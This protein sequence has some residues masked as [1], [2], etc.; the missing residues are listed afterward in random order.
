MFLLL[1]IIPTQVIAESD[2][3]VIDLTTDPVK[4]LFDLSNV[5]PGDSVYRNLV[6]KNDGDQD[7]NYL[8]SSKFTSG[9]EDFYNKLDLVIKDSNGVLYDGKLFKFNKLEPRL[10]KSN[11]TDQLLFYIKVPD[12]LGNT[13]QGLRTEFQFKF[14]VEGTLGGLLPAN[15]PRLPDTGG[16][17]FNILVSGFVMIL[18]GLFI[19]MMVRNQGK[20]KSKQ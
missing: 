12:D 2:S 4:V 10:L 6:I 15:G 20:M 9:L 19:Q 17:T 13:F 11:K 7:F 5:K 1:V 18:F 3:N 16:S 8:S 14:Y